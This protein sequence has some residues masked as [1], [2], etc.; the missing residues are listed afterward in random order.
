MPDNQNKK[1]IPIRTCIATGVK[2]P[3]N[4]LIRLVKLA[5]GTVLV[6]KT[7]KEK[8]RGANIDMDL[9][10][11][12]IAF[13][14]KLIERALKLERSLTEEERENLQNDFV[15]VIEEKAFRPSGKAVT[16]RIDKNKLKDKL[17][18]N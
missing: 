4:E 8:G 12:E 7:G 1:H 10:A 9:K 16:I 11:L 15:Q 3:K 6:D 5:N 17:R 13:K 18:K 14:K 2:K